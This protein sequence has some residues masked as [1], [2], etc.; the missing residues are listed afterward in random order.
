MPRDIEPMLATL[1]NEPVEDEEW[2]YE[3]KWDGYRAIAYM[4]KGKIGI[5]A[6]VMNA[7]VVRP[8]ITETTAMRAAY[9]A[10]LATGFWTSIEE[11]EKQWIVDRV[12]EPVQHKDTES[13][14]QQWHKAVKA[15][16][17]W[18]EE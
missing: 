15:A 16:K 10:G 11:I 12:F 17:A 3:M 2:V 9:L 13:M 7:K 18:A 6:T 5:Q 8:G 4:N 1:V 14:I